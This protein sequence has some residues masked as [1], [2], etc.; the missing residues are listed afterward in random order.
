MASAGYR[1][2]SIPALPA[3]LDAGVRRFLEAIKQNVEVAAAQR[4]NPL[5]ASMTFRDMVDAGLLSVK[6]GVTIDGTYYSASELLNLVEFSVPDWVTSDTAPPAPAGLVVGSDKTNTLLT[7]TLTTFDQYLFTEV[8]RATSNNL[9]TAVLIGSTTGNTYVDSLPTT[10]TTWF[11]WL[12][13]IAQNGLPGPFNAVSGTSAT[14]GPSTTTMSHGFYGQMV[15]LSWPTPVSSLAVQ[16]YRIRY[17]AAPDIFD[18]AIISA[19]SYRF[20]ANWGGARTFR[21]RAIDINGNESTET[22]YVVTVT[23]PSAP[24]ATIAFEGENAVITWP[25]LTQPANGSLPIDHYEIYKDSVAANNLL[26]SQYTTRFSYKADWSGAKNFYVRAVDSAGN[27]GASATVSV[28]ATLPGEVQNFMAEPIDNYALMSWDAPASLLPIVTYELRRGTTWAGGEVIG[29][30]TGLFTPIFETAGGSYTYWIAAINSAGQY[31]TPTSRTVTLSAPPDYVLALN[32]IST[33]STG[34]KVTAS[35]KS[36]AYYDG[37]G[38]VLPISTTQT[39]ATHFTGNGWD[40][41]IDQIASYP[42]YIQPAVSA[43]GTGY[44]QEEIDVGTTLAA[45]KVTVDYLLTALGGSPTSQCD[46]TTSDQ[47]NFT[48][49]STTTYTNTQQAFATNFRYIRVKITVTAPTLAAVAKITGLAIKL[50]AKLKTFSGMDT[51]LS[52][53]GK[54]IYLTADKTSTGEKVFVDVDSITLT[55]AGNSTTK[56]YTVYNFTDSPDPLSF[57]VYTFNSAGTQ[58]AN[59]FSYVVRGY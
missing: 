5:D 7:W 15:E 14:V 2:I 42:Y 57:D 20:A 54:T 46:I 31:G 34:G 41:P 44:Y 13:D 52:S 38:L 40:Q 29:T 26:S 35:V 32:N 22:T 27:A 21:I 36:N 18:L 28:D 3:G 24:A 30:K 4:G 23:A 1:P 11:Y 51:S 45:M 8:W 25:D 37:D 39:W 58:V 49:G 17:D 6:A 33:Y 48:G 10:G 19:N 56:I 9:S 55:A 47:A 50:D 53:G 16:F 12:R 43:G 59:G